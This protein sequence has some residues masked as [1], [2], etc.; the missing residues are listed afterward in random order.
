[1]HQVIRAG[2]HI[3]ELVDAS[4]PP[5]Q[6]TGRD[7][8]YFDIIGFDSRGVNNTTPRI[9]CFPNEHKRQEWDI[10]VAAE[11]LVGRSD[12]DFNVAWARAKALGKTC[13]QETDIDGMGR[14][15][16]SAQVV[17]DMV[18]IIERHGEWRQLEGKRLLTATEK[19]ENYEE[20]MDRLQWKRGME[21][22]QF[23]GISYGTIL[24]ATFSAMHPERVERVI[25]DGVV[26]VA[27]YYGLHWLRNLLD[28]DH[29]MTK[30]CEYCYE[31][32][33]HECPLYTGK[34]AYDVQIRVERIV[35]QL[36]QNPIEVSGSATYAPE[37][38]GYSDIILKVVA[39]LYTPTRSAE[40]LFTLLAVIEK[41]NGTSVARLKQDR[42]KPVSITTQCERDGPFSQACL[43]SHYI[44]TDGPFP[45]IA[46]MDAHGNGIPET[47]KQGFLEYIEA[48]KGQSR[49]MGEYWP[50]IRLGCVGWTIRPEWTFDGKQ[51]L[52]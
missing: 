1:M 6:T 18:E 41:G 24:G 34:S 39:A 21:K 22:L 40:E 49:W 28:T 29:I 20:T 4:T 46:C 5:S 3:Q 48:L 42:W 10:Q 37:V 45:G 12:A 23:W 9:K 25:L 32:G 7:A 35:D 52:S 17:E 33:P 16:N 26:D 50:L 14:Y 30:F 36:K 19:E 43:S 27:D 44:R 15:I 47:T 8:K 31:A 11:G 13:S 51:V 38:V 2:R